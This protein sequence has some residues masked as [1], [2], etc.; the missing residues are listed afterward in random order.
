[1]NDKSPLPGLSY[2]AKLKVEY[3]KDLEAEI[4]RLRGALARLIPVAYNSATAYD[5]KWPAIR[6]AEQ[7]L[8]GPDNERG[9]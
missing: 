6:E 4:K 3:V 2:I 8:A 9:D 7:A 5:D 1:M